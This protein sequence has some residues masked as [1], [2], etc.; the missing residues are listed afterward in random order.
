MLE[1]LG[2]SMPRE[3]EVPS[4]LPPTLPCQLLLSRLSH[5]L[6]SVY[7]LQVLPQLPHPPS[8]S[9]QQGVREPLTTARFKMVGAYPLLPQGAFPGLEGCGP[10][11]APW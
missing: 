8:Q 3:G 2:M 4:P 5:F 6:C 1:W 11:K 10:E 9:A 7:T